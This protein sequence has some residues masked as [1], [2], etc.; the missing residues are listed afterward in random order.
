[1][2][3]LDVH[4]NISNKAIT[5]TGIVQGLKYTEVFLN[6]AALRVALCC[7][8]NI[9]VF[10]ACNLNCYCRSQ[11]LRTYACN[12]RTALWHDRI[13]VVQWNTA[14]CSAGCCPGTGHCQ[15]CADI[16]CWTAV[17]LW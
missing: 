4:F 14:L 2:Y 8:T 5:S 1:M 10:P 17:L 13:T 15:L 12:I 9:R 3:I 16:V 6:P 7:Y 11:A